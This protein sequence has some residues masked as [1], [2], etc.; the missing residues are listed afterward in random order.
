MREV[1]IWGGN[2]DSCLNG[3]K[4]KAKEFGEVCRMEFNDKYL[5]STDTIDEAYLRILGMT[6][7]EQI[8][9]ER[10]WR[11]EYERREAEFKAKIPQ[12][13]EE[14]RKKARG[15]ILE[16]E[17]VYWDKIVPIRLYDLY[18]GMDLDCT[19]DLC[20]IMRDL[21]IVYAA[22]IEKA[23]DLFQTQGHSGMSAGLVM[24]MLRRF[25][26]DGNELADAIKEW[27]FEKDKKE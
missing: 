1:E 2:I 12:L 4:E 16:S 14:Y 13:T 9:H 3:L 6:K 18:H 24:S 21:N 15:L 27:R 17:L 20:R 8:E 7:A 5:L 22:R 26:P 19:L 11:E 23:Y 10:Q 25:C